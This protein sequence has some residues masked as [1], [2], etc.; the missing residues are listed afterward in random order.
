MKYD[1]QTLKNAID[2]LES[3]LS[4]TADEQQRIGVMGC[5]GRLKTLHTH[6]EKTQM[7]EPEDRL[8]REKAAHICDRDQFVATGYVLTGNGQKCIVD[9]SAV[10]WLDTDTFW[11]LMHPASR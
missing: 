10:R 8:T 11:N 1:Q 9:L 6:A 3:I 7:Q 5:I 2:E 4:V